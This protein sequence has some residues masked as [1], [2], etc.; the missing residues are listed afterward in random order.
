MIQPNTLLKTPPFMIEKYVLEPN[1]IALAPRGHVLHVGFVGA[2]AYAWVQHPVDS[3]IDMQLMTMPSG[4]PFEIE[5]DDANFERP[6]HVG[7]LV[8]PDRKPKLSKGMSPLLNDAVASV[9]HVF[10]F[11]PKTSGSI[12]IPN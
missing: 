6:S 5:I 7:S 3:P 11:M 10:M 12:I 8:A 9:W 1:G 2:V 4:G